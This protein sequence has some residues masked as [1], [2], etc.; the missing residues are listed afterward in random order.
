MSIRTTLLTLFGLIGFAFVVVVSIQFAG[1]YAAYHRAVGQVHADRIR[2]MV[3]E[4]DIAL[5]FE[6]EG[7]YHLLVGKPEGHDARKLAAETDRRFLAAITEMTTVDYG[8]TE[9]ATYQAVQLSLSDLR[10]RIMATLNDPTPDRSVRV[11][12]ARAWLDSL[13]PLQ[14]KLQE[15]RNRLLARS[16]IDDLELAAIHFFR[17]YAMVV[18]EHLIAN[19][20]LIEGEIVNLPAI[21]RAN[22][23]MIA[24]NGAQIDLAA[25]WLLEIGGLFQ[26]VND[27]QAGLVERIAAVRT[28]YRPAELR[29][30]QAMSGSG[31]ISTLAAAWKLQST[32]AIQSVVDVEQGMFKLSQARL[33]AIMAGAGAR[34]TIWAGLFVFAFVVVVVAVFVVVR[35]VVVPMERIRVAML[36]LADGDLTAELPTNQRLQEIKAMVDAL[37]VFKANGLRGQQLQQERVDLYARLEESHQKLH[38]DMQAAA[39]VQ[40]SQLPP[41]ANFGDI[42]FSTFFRPSRYLAGDTYDVVHHPDGRVTLF[43][44]DVAGHGAA[45]AFVSVASHLAARRAIREKPASADL[46]SIVA[47]I[48]RDWHKDL[49]Y[50]TMIVVEVDP[51]KKSGRLVQAGHPHARLL[52]RS[53]ELVKLGDGGLPVG[54]LA[55]T[56]YQEVA[57]PFAA[58]DRLWLVT[59]GIYEAENPEGEPFS[60]DRMDEFLRDG[61]GRTTSEVLDG[62]GK[63]LQSW[64]G[65]DTLEDDATIV[66]LEALYTHDHHG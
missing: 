34:S 49:P 21:S 62:I 20:A 57:F 19:E 43:E 40:L 60:E 8:M 64:C 16:G 12:A 36:R 55:E 4:T 3:L 17:N 28:V 10:A 51:K 22:M 15:A 54:V 2:F 9:A 5:A 53:G 48:N 52:R 33:T 37:R 23:D 7:V 56:D 24:F 41:P 30:A 13:L 35:R 39:A 46:A 42:G 6:K 65:T 66:V 45:A 14:F 44:I 18:L 25:D 1:A 61:L 26:A 11:S 58:G 29:L 59:D 32:A 27:P 47:R 38:D 63:N 31:N 50:F